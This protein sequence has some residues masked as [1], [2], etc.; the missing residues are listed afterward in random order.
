MGDGMLDT[1]LHTFLVLCETMHYTR[2]AERLC[3]TQP[4]VTHQIQS[5]ESHYGVRLFSY[6]GKTLRL[7]D[8][9]LRLRGLARSLAYNCAKAEQEMAQP[10]TV[11][12]RVGATKTIGEFVLAPQ[13]ERFLRENPAAKFSLLVENTQILLRELERGQLDFALVEGFFDREL[14][15]ARPYRREPF[16]GICAPGHRFAGEAVSLADLL[17]ERLLVREPGSGTRA[18]LEA[19]LKRRSCVP[20]S[21]AGLTTISDF[22][23]IKALVADGLGVSFMYQAAAARELAAGTLAPFSLEGEELWGTFHFVCLKDNAFADAWADW[24]AP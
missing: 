15:D 3:L 18:V 2:A 19:A 21:F 14:Y 10:A 5:L 7:T 16:V 9:G 12:L 4:A 6:E 11:S 23:M 8:A 22:A 24:A 13:V 17:E 20:D 1:R